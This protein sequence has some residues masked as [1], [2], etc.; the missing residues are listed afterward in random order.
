ML[1][2]ES[3]QLRLSAGFIFVKEISPEQDKVY[4][5][6]KSHLHNLLKGVEGVIF[7]ICLLV[8]IAQMVV[9]GDED[10]QDVLRTG[11]TL[12]GGHGYHNEYAKSVR[13]SSFD[14]FYKN[15]KKFYNLPLCLFLP[16][17]SQSTSHKIL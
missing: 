1:Y 11:L 8:S 12:L 4:I 2:L 17:D 3:P 14:K 10:T 13:N 15:K 16:Y 7:L 5:L 9:S 6:F